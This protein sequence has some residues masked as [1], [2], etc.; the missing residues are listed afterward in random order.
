MECLQMITQTQLKKMLNCSESHVQFL[1]ELG[2]IPAIKTGRN[3]MFSP[4]S[5][6]N[7]YN[8]YEGLDVSSRVKAIQSKKIVESR[9]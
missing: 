5:I 3:Y 4:I 2:I 6:Q 7:F 8:D 9:K 1:R